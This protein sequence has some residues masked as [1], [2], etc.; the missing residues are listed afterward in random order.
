MVVRYGEKN[1]GRGQ[2]S[3]NYT[4]CKKLGPIGRQRKAGT[5][6]LTGNHILGVIRV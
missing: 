6:T 1:G 4:S 5:S 3:G 2:V